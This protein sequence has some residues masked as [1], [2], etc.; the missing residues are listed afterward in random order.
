MY[1]GSCPDR[2]DRS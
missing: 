2:L 1:H